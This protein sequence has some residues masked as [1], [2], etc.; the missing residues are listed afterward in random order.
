MMVI[1]LGTGSRGC[2]ILSAAAAISSRSLAIRTPDKVT[3]LRSGCTTIS[4]GM[5]GL[6]LHRALARPRTQGAV[7]SRFGAAAIPCGGSMRVLVI[8]VGGTHVKLLATG[9]RTP[10]KIDSGPALTPARMVREVKRA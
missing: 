2:S 4:N 10:V 9:R 6:L 8:D 5:S 1:R 7:Y 3:R